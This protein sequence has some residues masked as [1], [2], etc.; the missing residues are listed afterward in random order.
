MIWVGKTKNK[1]IWG[2]LGLSGGEDI[3][4]E[5]M[6]FGETAVVFFLE[7]LGGEEITNRGYHNMTFGEAAVVFFL[8]ILDGAQRASE[9][10]EHS[11]DFLSLFS[12]SI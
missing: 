4:T 2:G 8:E 6:T 5:G 3:T 10:S 11:G 9:H 12:S 7:I 1:K